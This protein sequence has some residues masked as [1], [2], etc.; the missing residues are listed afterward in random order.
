MTVRSMTARR[1][2]LRALGVLAL[3]GLALPATAAS[4][5]ATA[6]ASK[7]CTRLPLSDIQFGRE[8]TIATARIRLDEYATEVARRRGWP[9]FVKSAE[10][11][12]CEDYLFIPLLGQ[13]YKCLVTAT[14]C[15]K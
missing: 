7:A 2:A 9:G 6:S 8:Q 4:P 1:Q 14:F 10:V 3:V 5:A 15:S 12:S 13:E 11:V